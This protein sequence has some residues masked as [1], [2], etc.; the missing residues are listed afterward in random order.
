MAKNKVETCFSPIMYPHF[1]NND[2]IVVVVDILRAT[3][4]IGAAFM[5]GIKKIIPVSTLDEAREYKN[6][7]YLVAA[8][9]DGIVKEFADF[10]NSPFNFTREKVGG[11]EVVYSTTNGTN[12]IMLAKGSYKV[13][14]GSYLCITAISEYI[15]KE[16]RDV[17]LLCAGWKNKFNLEDSLFCGALAEKLLKNENYSTICDSTKAALDLW[18]IAKPNPYG[19]IL[20]SAQKRRLQKNGLDDVI[21]FCHE[22]DQTNIIPYLKDGHL[23]AL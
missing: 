13:I 17:L 15:I 10:G 8:E 18:Q 1:E 14:I 3:T 9:R 2:A 19:Y 4:A 20:K 5:N 12:T 16:G 23:C 22:A 7:G 21:E 6:K 11:K